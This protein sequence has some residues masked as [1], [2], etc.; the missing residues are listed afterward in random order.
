MPG[1]NSQIPSSP[2]RNGSAAHGSSAWHGGSSTSGLPSSATYGTPGLGTGGT[3]T[4]GGGIGSG[5]L[6]SSRRSSFFNGAGGG[7]NSIEHFASSYTRAQSFLAIEPPSEISRQR[8]FFDETGSPVIPSSFAS[9]YRPHFDE[10][11]DFTD[12]IDEDGY[13]SSTYLDDNEDASGHIST[14]GTEPSQ[15]DHLLGHNESLYGSYKSTSTSGGYLN[16]PTHNRRHPRSRRLSLY[17]AEPDQGTHILGESQAISTGTEQD[18]VIIQKVEDEDGHI[19]TVIA[20]QSTAPQTV[21]NS[22]NILIGIGLLALPLG[23]RY[24][25]WVIGCI[26]LVISAASTFYSAKLLAKCLDTDSTI[27]TYADVAYAAFGSR[28]RILVSMLFTI[29]LMGAGVSLVVL[30]SDSLHSLVPSISQLQWK[31]VAFA[32]LTPPC[33]LPLR[34]LSFSSIMGITATFALVVIVLFDGFYKA[35]SPGSLL[36]PATTWM[37]PEKWSLLPMS[38]GIFMAPWGG[39]AVF[40]NIYRDMRHPQKYGQCLKTTY[41]ITF[42]VDASMGVLGFLMFGQD[43]MDEVTKS[44]LLTPGYP[45]SLNYLITLLIATIPL[46]K[47]PLN[48]RPIVSTLDILFGIDKVEFGDKTSHHFGARIGKFLVRVSVVAS[49]VLMAIAFP[50]FDRIIAFFG[51]LLCVTICMILPLSFYLKLYAGRISKFELILD[52]ILLVFF[53]ILAIVGTIWCMLPADLIGRE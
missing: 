12:A 48:A 33:F 52:Y 42:L 31:F 41:K 3:T 20:G 17:T 9:R 45:E 10:G 6:T 43:V 34:I 53:S 1:T 19:T 27:V 36:H 23:F 38:I 18:P 22:V 13:E 25:G 47:T 35:D 32:I 46:A 40:P 29:E 51:S 28:A 4:T 24:A 11:T 16:I 44:I 26:L 2:D 30:F 37:W 8:S 15:T 5:N 49:F 50:D 21:F 7:L 14:G 39:H